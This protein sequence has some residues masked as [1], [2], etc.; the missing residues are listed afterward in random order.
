[1][2]KIL[3]LLFISS[4]LACSAKA[5]DRPIDFKKIPTAAQ[6]FVKK[7]FPNDPVTYSAKDDDLIRPDYKVVLA[8]GVKIEFEHNGE[9]DKIEA[10]SGVPEAIIP[11]TIFGYVE[12][13][14]VGL[15][16]V[17]YEVGDYDYEVKLSNG[18]ELK[19]NKS[20]NLIEIDD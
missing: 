14:Y 16:I 10:Y 1:M 18:L 19:F 2:K 8:S 7:Y 6:N 5:D 13:N 4:L 12:K 15:H 3:A 11:P 9:L 17:E 20:F